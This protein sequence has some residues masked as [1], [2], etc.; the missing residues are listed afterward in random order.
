M[1]VVGAECGRWRVVRGKSS[2]LHF[3]LDR[4]Q[5][6]GLGP[7]EARILKCPLISHMSSKGQ[8]LGPLVLLFQD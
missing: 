5:Y 2:M 6:S 8:G 4:L 7:V 1:F 3:S